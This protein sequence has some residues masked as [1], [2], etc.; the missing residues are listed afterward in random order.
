MRPEKPTSDLPKYQQVFEELSRDLAEG[1]YLPGQKLPSEAALVRRFGA[2]R[3]TVGRAMND[4]RRA[5]LIER[6]AGSGTYVRERAVPRELA[7]GLSFGLLIPDLG[8]TEIFEPICQG[9]AASPQASEHAL[10]WCDTSTAIDGPPG[11]GARKAWEVCQKYIAR[12]VDGVF[13]APLEFPAPDQRM[14]QKIIAALDQAGIPVVLLDRD[15]LP[16]PGRSRHDLVGIDNRRTGFAATEHLARLGARRIAMLS[17][18][19]GPATIQ[20][21]LAGY[22]EALF[23]N[24]LPVEPELVLQLPQN[25]DG[26]IGR[27]IQAQRPDGFVCVNDRAAGRLMH[28]L[29]AIGVRVPEDVRIIGIDDI[30]Y[31]NLLPVPLSTMHQPCREIGIAAMSTM[32]ERIQRPGMPVRD[33]LLECPLIIRKSCGSARTGETSP[34]PSASQ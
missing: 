28:A 21:R 17:Y 29:L 12:R 25:D 5:G 16:Y 13:F 11:E 33:V 23:T 20:E 1:R 7:G 6:R 31:A 26:G 14:N 10:I 8:R 34:A 22:R 27:F 24:G 4:L 30:A 3:I 19:D 2:S 9:M 15:V 32:I 18:P